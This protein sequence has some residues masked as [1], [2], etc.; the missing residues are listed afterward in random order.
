VV[1]LI[2]MFKWQPVLS[3]VDVVGAVVYFIGDYLA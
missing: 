3:G 1:S 2:L